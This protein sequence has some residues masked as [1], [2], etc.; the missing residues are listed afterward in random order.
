MN[1]GE[2]S[3][4]ANFVSR[5]RR[6]NKGGQGKKRRASAGQANNGPGIPPLLQEKFF[7]CAK[8]GYSTKDCKVSKNAE[9]HAC[10]KQ[11]HLKA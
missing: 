3:E 11:G 1:I 6:Q 7:H 9:C 5:N 2:S 10:K 8:V 4:K